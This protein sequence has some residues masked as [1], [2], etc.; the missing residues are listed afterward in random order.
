[1]TAQRSV[2]RVITSIET[3]EGD[4]FIV[5]RPFPTNKCKNIDPFLLVDHLGPITY[6]PNEAKGA[7]WHPHRGFETISYILQGEMEHKDSMGNTG[8]LRAGDIQWM[9]AGS[10][11]IHDEGPSKAM[12]EKGGTVEGFQIWVNLPADKKMIPPYYQD[13]NKEKIPEIKIGNTKIKVIA[14]ESY[15]Q[16]A[17]IS[18][19]IPIMYLDVH[20][21]ANE[22]FTL[23]IPQNMN[24]LCYI[25]RGEALFG[26]NQ[27]RAVQYDMVDFEQDG[28]EIQVNVIK[29]TQFL[30][31]AGVPLNEPIVQYGPFV[32]NTQEQIQQAFSD[33]RSGKFVQHKA[34]MKSKTSHQTQFDPNSASIIIN[35]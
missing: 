35:N 17:I 20:T 33:Y 3:L 4:G 16:K 27:K 19:T 30:V 14:G 24:A 5:H 26:K 2:K 8:S 34:D 23:S 32:M 15:G 6:G 12:L 10:G 1:M 28:D 22:N 7:P 25:Y 18:T 11:I 31:L 9:T 21:L 13:I 29:N